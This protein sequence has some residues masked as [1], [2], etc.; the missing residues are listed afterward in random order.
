[1]PIRNLLE[2]TGLDY[3]VDNDGDL[4]FSNDY[5]SFEVSD[6]EIRYTTNRPLESRNRFNGL[7]SSNVDNDVIRDFKDAL[8]SVSLKTLT[9]V[10]NDDEGFS[11]FRRDYGPNE[12]GQV[13]EMLL[14]YIRF[15]PQ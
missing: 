13:L 10:Q 5:S 8:R 14:E 4:N 1:M 6:T 12:E 15:D 9:N 7:H 11:V 3:D 2:N